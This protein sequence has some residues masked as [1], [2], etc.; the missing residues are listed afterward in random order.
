VLLLSGQDGALGRR[1]RVRVARAREPLAGQRDGVRRRRGQVAA[2]CSRAAAAE[3]ARAGAG[4]R[5]GARWS[6][7]GGWGVGRGCS[8]E[9]RWGGWEAAERTEDKAGSLEALG[10]RWGHVDGSGS[11]GGGTVVGERFVGGRLI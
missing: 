4:V 2:R 9:L 3:A 6:G 1:R 11:V 10:E 7:I 8:G 5:R